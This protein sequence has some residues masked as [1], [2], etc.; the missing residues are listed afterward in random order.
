M[1]GESG[2]GWVLLILAILFELSGT[3]S[4]KLSEGFTRFWPS[5]LMFI[6][7]GCSFTLLNFA[8]TYIQVG[9]AYAIWSGVGIVL[10]TLVGLVLFKESFNITQL[11]WILLIVVGVIG[12][13]L[14]SKVH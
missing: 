8:L 5:I 11:A 3:T 10:I 12:L 4:M 1:K 7:Y 9:V 14:S 6:L 13:K 2:L